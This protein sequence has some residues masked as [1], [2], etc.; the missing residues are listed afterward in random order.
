MPWKA[1]YTTSNERSLSDDDLRWPEGRRAAFSVIVDLDPIC[2]P[3]GLKPESFQTPEAYFGMHDG[4]DAVRTTLDGHGVKATFVASAVTAV[5]FPQVLTSLARDGHEIATTGLARENTETLDPDEEG[6]RI[7]LAT[8]QMAEVLGAAPKGW[9]ALPRAADR[10]AVG[11]ISPA[12]AGLLKA[13]GYAYLGGGLADDIPYYHVI[14]ADRGAA[15][16]ALPYYYHYDD[17]FF[18]MF[19]ARG[20]GL[21]HADVL[22]RN[23]TRQLKAQTARGRCTSIVVHPHLIGWGHRWRMFD[24]LIARAAETGGL[25]AATGADLASHWATEYPAGAILNL[26]P[27]IWQDYPDS[28]S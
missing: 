4:L 9:F 24:D 18:L 6:R 11:G 19:P 15:L 13:A 16:L 21:E 8:A 7:A 14:D 17:Q 23:W 20:T 27:S 25:W 10:Y 3:E 28:L 1:G 2:S 22:G 26:K 5:C 12:M